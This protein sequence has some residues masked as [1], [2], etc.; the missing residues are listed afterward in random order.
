MLTRIPVSTK[1]GGADANWTLVT[2]LFPFCGWLVG[3]V[4]AAPVVAVVLEI[5]GRD[6]LTSTESILLGA[7]FAAGLAWMT[8]AFHLD[9]FCDVV[10]AATA[11]L[12]SKERRMEI[13]G[14]SVTGAAAACGVALLL[15]V[16]TAA[17]AE[18]IG[19][20]ARL[21]EGR[22]DKLSLSLIPV[23]VAAPVLGRMAMLALAWI[24][25]YPK[26]SGTGKLAVDGAKFPSIVLGLLATAPL[27]MFLAPGPLTAAG[28]AAICVALYWRVKSAS[29]FGGVT[30]D[31]LGACCESAECAAAVALALV[32]A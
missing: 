20:S 24:G 11:P 30:G 25:D 23:L 29:L 18:I 13:A 19:R 32:V 22:W 8:R 2:G 9:G 6:A 3:V 31:V 21:S 26:D 12:A 16:K 17:Y 14:D 7:L 5:S 28:F 4:C 27:A 15:I 10:D 1:G